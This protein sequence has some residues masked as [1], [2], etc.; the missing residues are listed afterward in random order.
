MEIP[1]LPMPPIRDT[2]TSSRPEDATCFE[3]TRDRVLLFFGHPVVGKLFIVLAVIVS[4]AIIGL[5]MRP[6]VTP[7]PYRS[8]SFPAARPA[9]HFTLQSASA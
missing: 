4:F 9:A 5:G 8:V 2:L 7:S 1:G 3:R 6:P